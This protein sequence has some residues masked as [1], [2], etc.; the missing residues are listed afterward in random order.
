MS[1]N[2]PLYQALAS[3]LNAIKNCKKTG[4]KEWQAKHISR[5]HK[6]VKNHMPSGAGID[7]GTVFIFEESTE[8]RLVFQMDFHHMDDNGFYDGWTEH[9][10]TVRA[11]L[12]F[13]LDIKISGE[14]RDNVKEMLHEIAYSAL[15]EKVSRS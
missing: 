4:N 13:E 6:L 11:S 1:D 10:V 14:D 3:S 2:I 9:T 8:N 7:R 5:L 15:T 12:A